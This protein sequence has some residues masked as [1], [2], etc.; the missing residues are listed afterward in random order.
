[1]NILA[2]LYTNSP[3]QAIDDIATQ[4]EKNG[5][6]IVHFLYFANIAGY[7]LLSTKW[8]V[9]S[10]KKA[11]NYYDSLLTADFL[12]PDGIA[13][14]I[15]YRTAVK[16][17]R[18]QSKKSWLSN[19]NGT[20]LTL[21]LLQQIHHGN[22]VHIYWGTPT[23]VQGAAQFLRTQDI[24]PV[25]ATHGYVD[26][27]WSNVDPSKKNILLIGRWTPLQEQWVQDHMTQIQ[28]HNMLV[29]SVGWLFD[30]W[31]GEE[32]RTPKIF[33]GWAEWLRRLI[34]NPRKNAIKV[35]Y[36]LYLPYAIIRYLLLKR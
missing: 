8:K 12:L 7:D 14:Q 27:D 21:P 2:K 6:C 5:H 16:T 35:R 1:M 22:P 32:K 28:K 34:I 9:Q 29:V 20:D 30:F 24:V 13:L 33:R 36:S 18:I 4:R 10:T 17:N 26:F 11:Y 19:C 25:S 23:G 3:K 31:S 15:F